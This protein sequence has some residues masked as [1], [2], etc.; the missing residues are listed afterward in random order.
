[1]LE[2][3]GDPLG[4][5]GREIAFDHLAAVTEFSG[6]TKAHADH[7]AGPAA[8]DAIVKLISRTPGWA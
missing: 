1:L 8:G 5:P 4:F 6:R 2:R 7:L 3:V